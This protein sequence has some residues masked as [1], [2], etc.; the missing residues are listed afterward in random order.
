MA[1]RLDGK[2]AIVTGGASGIGLA[3]AEGFAREGAIVCIGDLSCEK[4][5]AAAS[6]IGQA[7]I[8][9]ALD[10]CDAGSCAAAVAATV[11]RA[12]K[13][14]ILINSAGVFGMGAITEISGD[15]FDRV[16]A[17]N[18]KGL[19]LMIQA[20]AR[21][22]IAGGSGGSIVT[23]ASGAGRRAAPGAVAYSA[24]KAAAIS[25]AQCAG[26]ELIAHGIRSNAIAPGA[27]R[28]PM[29]AEVDK[30]FS[31]VHNL[32]A[33]S[34]EAVQVGATPVGRM[35]TPDDFVGAALFLASDE[36]AYVLG[37]TLNVD[38]GMVLS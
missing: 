28:T 11:A 3:I 26:L 9:V 12:G 38:G 36:S 24:S 5:E 2:A 16:M 20:A 4:S 23:I 27:V 18:A 14:D 22:M 19:M 15:E 34:A 29:W 17:V 13:L 1:G 25:I 8:G 6:A 35:A 32:E 21:A 31:S 30:L 10:V 7:A 33:G 37:Q